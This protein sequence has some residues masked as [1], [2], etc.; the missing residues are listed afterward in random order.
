MPLRNEAFKVLKKIN[1]NWRGEET[2]S[3]SSL[4]TILSKVLNKIFTNF[5]SGKIIPFFAFKI[6]T[7]Q[8][9]KFKPSAN[10]WWHLAILTDSQER[11]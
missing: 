5:V 9:S 2:E 7:I 11:E 3:G 6:E 4:S 8:K 1:N 10:G